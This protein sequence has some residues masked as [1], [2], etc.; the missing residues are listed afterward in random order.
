MNVRYTDESYPKKTNGSWQQKDSNCSWK[1][2]S[3]FVPKE[4]SFSLLSHEHV[5]TCARAHT[6]TLPLLIF[7]LLFSYLVVIGL[8]PTMDPEPQFVNHCP[9][10][11]L[12]KV[13]LMF[14]EHQIMSLL[15]PGITSRETPNLM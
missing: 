15:W 14:V 4:I 13:S 11:C 10:L 12:K 6:H 5:R 9:K 7:W 8:R 3:T 2:V 1:L